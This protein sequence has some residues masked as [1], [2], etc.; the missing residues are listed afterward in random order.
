MNEHRELREALGA[1]VLGGLDPSQRHDVEAHL[2]TCPECRE[3][4]ADL[5]ALPPLLGRLRP[6]EAIGELTSAPVDV[7][8]GV[9]VAIAD[10]RRRLNTSMW[11]WRAATAAAVLA[12]VFAWQPWTSPPAEDAIQAQAQPAAPAAQETSG[13]A[14]AYAWEWGTTVQ[15]DVERLPAR[16]GYVLWAV[17]DNGVRQQAGAWGPTAAGGAK[18]RGASAIQ[19]DDLQRVEVTDEAG[20]LLL[21][22]AFG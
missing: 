11:A 10:E 1:Y 9:M 7:L 5:A 16:D 14:D 13:V 19:R 17:S 4:V 2:Q 6:D 20:E 12:L 22:F 3:E 21:V 8:D 15:L 18:V